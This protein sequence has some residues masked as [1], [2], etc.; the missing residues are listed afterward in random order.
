M[1]FYE[2][3]FPAALSEGMRGGPR[4][5]ATI[6]RTAS[7]Y[8]HTNVNW[9]QELWSWEADATLWDRSKIE[10]A[11]AFF[12]A[13]QG[14]GNG[15]R[16]RNWLDYQ[17]I[18]QTLGTG[19]GVRTAFQIVKTSTFGA[20]SHTRTIRKPVAGTVAVSVDGLPQASGWS[21]AT[22][23]GVVTFDA[24]PAAGKVVVAD[25]LFDYPAAFAADSADLTQNFVDVAEWSV[26]IEEIRL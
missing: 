13:V 25:C 17:V 21:V 15:F 5:A 10:Q 16:F 7:G 11:L 18:G 3:T 19:D 12:R 26:Q 6:V 24:A 1:A 9:A 20:Y 2:L 23:T 22:S 8:R 4:F 14:P